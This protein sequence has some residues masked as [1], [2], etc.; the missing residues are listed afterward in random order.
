MTFHLFFASLDESF[1]LVE[2]S[3]T[4]LCPHKKVEG[5]DGGGGHIRDPSLALKKRP[6][7]AR[8]ALF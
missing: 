1:H 8:R 6:H 5:I 4:D 3:C 2:F 7:R